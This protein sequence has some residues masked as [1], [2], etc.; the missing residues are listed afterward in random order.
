[1]RLGRMTVQENDG[2][3]TTELMSC[4]HIS[5]L[6]H[7]FLPLPIILQKATGETGSFE[8]SMQFTLILPKIL[9]RF[10][11]FDDG[12][13]CPEVKAL[14][15]F[16]TD[17]VHPAYDIAL[18]TW[19]PLPWL[20]LPNEL[21]GKVEI[22]DILCIGQSGIGCEPLCE[23]SLLEGLVVQQHLWVIVFIVMD[24]M[25]VLEM[26]RQAIDGGL[27]LM[28]LVFQHVPASL[29]RTDV[30]GAYVI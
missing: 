26:D 18:T 19:L 11:A 24:V 16:G 6:L 3:K 20:L 2:E 29:C 14:S 28:H 21:L 9:P 10:S 23:G 15:S 30:T 1:M 17:K 13:E 4:V 5:G 25:L 8:G 7:T 27:L 22:T 12:Q